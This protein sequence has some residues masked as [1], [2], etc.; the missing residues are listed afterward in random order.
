MTG[1]DPTENIMLA[2]DSG[3]CEC[4]FYSFSIEKRFFESSKEGKKGNDTA[5][6]VYIFPLKEIAKVTFGHIS[7]NSVKPQVIPDP[8]HSSVAKVV[9]PFTPSPIWPTAIK[10]I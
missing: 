2:R 4:S 6:N 3:I 9:F 7:D 10:D 1:H 8:Y 5:D